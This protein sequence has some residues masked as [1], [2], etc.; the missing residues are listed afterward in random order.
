LSRAKAIV[1]VA[2]SRR[3][4][5]LLATPATFVISTMPSLVFAAQ[6]TRI[7]VL[8][9]KTETIDGIRTAWLSG[10]DAELEEI[11]QREGVAFSRRVVE[12]ATGPHRAKLA[13]Q[14]LLRDGCQRLTGLFSGNFA[15][16]IPESLAA[17]GAKFI[18]ADLGAKSLSLPISSGVER[19]GPNLWKQAYLC[20]QTL[21]QQG[22]LS[23]VVAC[24][25][26]ESG[27]DLTAAFRDGY[28]GAGGRHVEF[29]V[30]GTPELPANE[31]AWQRIDSAV[32]TH[33]AD[34]VF[35]LYSGREAA[36][37]LS[38]FQTAFVGASARP[39]LAMLSS[40]T[41]SL[42][43]ERVDDFSAIH[44]MA[45]RATL[46]NVASRQETIFKQTGRAA[47]RG[48]IASMTATTTSSSTRWISR[49]DS[50]TVA[51]IAA[52][53]SSV[54]TETLPDCN[55]D[56]WRSAQASAGWFLPYGA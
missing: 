53:D 15:N 3:R 32:V 37:F 13:A 27:F 12:Y 43:R 19:V 56:C 23:A 42:P 24:S 38:Y 6:R 45:V 34:A 33:R 52:G 30:T 26:Y 41:D 44:A 25:F 21:A 46:E 48:L 29:A 2:S 10:F 16:Q 17:Y 55:N 28:I 49:V 35:A 31:F 18:I 36:G 54:R 8:L 50:G 22:S 51:S 47:A 5:L 1:E 14:S 20:G 7:G 40:L 39:T 11:S 9:P 4:K